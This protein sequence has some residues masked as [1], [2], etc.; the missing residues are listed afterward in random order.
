M[1]VICIADAKRDTVRPE[2]VPWKDAGSDSFPY[3]VIQ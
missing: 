2:T 3:P 1:T